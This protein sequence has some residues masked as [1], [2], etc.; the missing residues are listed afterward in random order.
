MFFA[1]NL[2]LDLDVEDGVSTGDLG[3][4]VQLYTRRTQQLGA[5]EALG[6]GLAMFVVDHLADVAERILRRTLSTNHLQRSRHCHDPTVAYTSQS[7][8]LYYVI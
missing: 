3:V 6:C 8:R 4:L 7:N 1:L 5:V 2:L